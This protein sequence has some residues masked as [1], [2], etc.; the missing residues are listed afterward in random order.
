VSDDCKAAPLESV[1]MWSA[2]SVDTLPLPC[3]IAQLFVLS[4]HNVNIANKL[5]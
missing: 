5:C 2:V 3:F 4:A 1:L